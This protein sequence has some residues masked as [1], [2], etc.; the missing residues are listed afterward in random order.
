MNKKTYK[1][2]APK[3]KGFLF[4]GNF[5]VIK[6]DKKIIRSGEVKYFY[7]DE[8][9]I[10]HK[11]QPNEKL[12]RFATR[13]KNLN[14]FLVSKYDDFF[15]GEIKIIDK[16]LEDKKNTINIINALKKRKKILIDS[17]QI[18]KLKERRW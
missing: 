11:C 8:K 7:R 4:L 14:F 13:D 10:M 1:G 17:K 16:R 15:N 3:D 12:K 18:G 2:I 9:N 5:E 6:E